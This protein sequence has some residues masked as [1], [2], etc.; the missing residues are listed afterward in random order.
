MIDAHYDGNISI[1][2]F[3]TLREAIVIMKQNYLHLLACRYYRFRWG[4]ICYDLLRRKE[5]EVDE[6]T[7]ELGLSTIGLS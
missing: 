1:I 4:C 2:E 5:P 7:H 3:H 6:L